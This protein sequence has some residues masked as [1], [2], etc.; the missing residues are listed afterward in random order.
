MNQV[1]SNTS[2]NPTPPKKEDLYATLGEVQLQCTLQL[3][4]K[5]EQVVALILACLGEGLTA[6]P[7]IV[8]AIA[9]L[10]YN[11]RHVGKILHD[12]D[13]HLWHR[14]GLRITEASPSPAA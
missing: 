11:H 14:N 5:N 4:N 12:N 2:T 7:S 9:H 1:P 3:C 10:G 13:G 6:A 8:G